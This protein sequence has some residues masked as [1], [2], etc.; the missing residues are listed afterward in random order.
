MSDEVIRFEIDAAE[1]RDIL[2]VL[3]EIILKRDS[4]YEGRGS[5]V[6]YARNQLEAE[7]VFVELEVETAVFR[8][9]Q[10]IT[11][12]QDL[13]ESV[14]DD[15]DRLRLPTIDRATRLILLR[16]PGLREVLRLMYAIK[17]VQ[18]SLGLGGARAILTA[19]LFI[20]IT[21]TGTMARQ[22]RKQDMLEARFDRLENKLEKRL[23]TMEEAVRGYGGLPENYRETVVG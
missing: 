6:L 14:E 5:G 2:N 16:I 20:L 22:K 19:A 18:T 10:D 15:A 12:V 7:M 8:L 21:V 23:I 11:G 17:V 3:D 1:L 4:I 9:T 13:L